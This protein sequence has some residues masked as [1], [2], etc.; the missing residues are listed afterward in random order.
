MTRD[1]RRTVTYLTCL[2]ALAFILAVGIA[3]GSR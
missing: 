1:Q 3:G 2:A